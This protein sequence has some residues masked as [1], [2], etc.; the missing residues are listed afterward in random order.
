[1]VLSERITSNGSDKIQKPRTICQK[2][3]ANHKQRQIAR[4]RI[5]YPDVKAAGHVASAVAV[6]GTAVAVAVREAR[7]L[8]LAVVEVGAV[9]VVDRVAFLAVPRALVLETKIPVRIGRVLQRLPHGG[10]PGV[11]PHG[12]AI[13]PDGLAQAGGGGELDL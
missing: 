13:D 2:R 5:T 7:R 3:P 4:E 6:R 10:V 12:S 1:V 9:G 11:G 8:L